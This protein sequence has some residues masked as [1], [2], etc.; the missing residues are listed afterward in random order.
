[1][2]NKFNKSG[3]SMKSGRISP[4]SLFQ[5]KKAQGMKSGRIS[6]I[7]LFQEKKAQMKIQ[8]MAFMLIALMIFFSLV[9]LLLLKVKF[10]G[11]K[12]KATDIS[13]KNA[14]L[15]VEKLANSPEFSCGMSFD[16]SKFS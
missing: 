14:I 9:G 11:L 5:E 1:M 12:E 8:Q 2:K 6:P 4:I 15:L 7:S 10:S 16:E 3:Q 13:E